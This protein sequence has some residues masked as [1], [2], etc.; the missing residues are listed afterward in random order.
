MLWLFLQKGIPKTW[1]SGI[2][3]YT[4]KVIVCIRIAA[5]YVV[6]TGLLLL[7]LLEVDSKYHN[8]KETLLPQKLNYTIRNVSPL[9]F[10]LQPNGNII[11]ILDLIS[12]FS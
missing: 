9:I 6:H 2:Y 4:F 5:A 11:F 7:K 10:T 8:L 3:M 12:V 1:P